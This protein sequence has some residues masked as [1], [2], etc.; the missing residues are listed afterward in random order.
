MKKIYVAIIILFTAFASCK[1]NSTTTV[2]PAVQAATDDATIQAY[3]TA[4]NITAIKDPSGLY[5]QIISQGTGITPTVYNNVTV[6]YTGML[7]DGTVFDSTPVGKP[8]KFALSG[9]IK[10]WQIGLPKLQAGGKILLLIPSGLGYGAND[11]GTVPANSV[12]V[13]TIELVSVS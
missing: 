10:G 8:S 1:K 7:V 13:F 9:L 5:Y 4:H 6:N 11:S 12:L 2:D 3:I